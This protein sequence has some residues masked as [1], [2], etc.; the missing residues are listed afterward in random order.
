MENLKKNKFLIIFCAILVV[1]VVLLLYFDNK[2]NKG[3]YKEEENMSLKHY[4]ENEYIPVNI[5]YDQMARIYLQDYVYKLIY[6]IDGAYDLLDDAYKLSKFP[7]IETFKDYVSSMM[8]EKTREMTVVKY[9]VTDKVDYRY[10]DVYDTNDNLFIFKET[11]VMQYSV[12]FDRYTVDM[13]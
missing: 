10:F 7:T 1:I 6:D 3:N 9:S 12:Y 5:T 4:E 11:G 2:E 13:K 8:S